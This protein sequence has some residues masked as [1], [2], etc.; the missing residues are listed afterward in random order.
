VEVDRAAIRSRVLPTPSGA[1]SLAR[2]VEVVNGRILAAG[3]V[4]R[5]GRS[6]GVA[7]LEPAAGAGPV[8]QALPLPDGF[9]N[10][11]LNG[12]LPSSPDGELLLAAGTAW[13]LPDATRAYGAILREGRE[14]YAFTMAQLR[15]RTETIDKDETIT[16]SSNWTESGSALAGDLL[17][18]ATGLVQAG[19]LLPY[20]VDGVT[21]ETPDAVSVPVGAVAG[22]EREARATR[23]WQADGES[24]RVAPRGTAPE[25]RIVIE[26][27][28]AG[29][30]SPRDSASGQA[31]LRSRIEPQNARSPSTADVRLQL[32][33]PASGSWVEVGRLAVGTEFADQTVVIDD[34]G[35]FVVTGG[36]SI[37]GRVVVLAGSERLAY[38]LDQL[39]I[40]RIALP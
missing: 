4:S 3:E 2:S 16:I 40:G 29:L 27:T 8:L 30:K 28:S 22:P 6:R 33:E 13:N 37:R 20:V 31:T 19:L 15:G 18:A 12:L 10:S 21:I 11:S 36:S 9:D 39:T 5:G 32:L 34:P 23:L 26:F 24:L 35:R 14:P 25:L 7:W 38:E 1:S 17:M